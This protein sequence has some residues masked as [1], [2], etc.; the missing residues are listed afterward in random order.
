M[1]IYTTTLTIPANTSKAAPKEIYLE[2]EGELLTEVHIVIP[3]GHAGLSGIAVFYG[4]KQLFP[5]PPGEWLYGDNERILFP[6]RWEIPF[7]KASLRILGYNEDDTYEHSFIIRFIVARFKE[8][9]LEERM[10]RT[11]ELLEEIRD[12]SRAALGL[13]GISPVVG[14]EELIGRGIEV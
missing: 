2:L 4:I 8:E 14:V 10:Q 7:A 13:P 5:L 11:N 6:E 9:L 3:P 1:P 12:L